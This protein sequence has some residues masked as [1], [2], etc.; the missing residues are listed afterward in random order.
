METSREDYIKTGIDNK[1]PILQIN[2]ALSK[3]GF[4]PL[5]K[6]EE[7]MVNDGTYGTNIFQRFGKGAKDL[8]GG[9]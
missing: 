6:A 2:K 9:L 8:G 3:G 5:T 1:L 4:K 7:I